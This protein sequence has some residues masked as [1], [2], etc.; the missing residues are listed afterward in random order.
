MFNLDKN[1]I[2]KQHQPKIE[3]QTELKNSEQQVNLNK[4]Y[5]NQIRSKSQEK[6]ELSSV[7]P[8]E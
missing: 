5:E 2:W 6:K 7:N 1:S 3:T 4:Q 8:I